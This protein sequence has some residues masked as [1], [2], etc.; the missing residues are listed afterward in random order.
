MPDKTTRSYALIT[1]NMRPAIARPLFLESI[2]MIDV[3]SVASNP[4]KPTEDLALFRRA[5]DKA[6]KLSL[7]NRDTIPRGILAA[8]ARFN[9]GSRAEADQNT[10]VLIGNWFW[11]I[12]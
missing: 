8:R 7:P 5:I 1:T 11:N 3:S 6:G 2:C 10:T 12:G 9:R 4:D